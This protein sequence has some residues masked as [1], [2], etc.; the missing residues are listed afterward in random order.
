MLDIFRDI[1]PIVLGGLLN[2]VSAALRNYDSVKLDGL[3]RMADFAKWVVAAE[4]A[5]P[6]PEGAF[7]QAYHINQMTAIETSLE[8]D[9]LGTAV[10]GMMTTYEEWEGSPTELYELLESQVDET[11]RNGKRWPGSPNW[12]SQRLKRSASFLRSVGID[13]QFPEQGA[14]GKNRVFRIRTQNTVDTVDTV[15]DGNIST[16]SEEIPS[17]VNPCPGAA[18]DAIDGIDDKN[19]QLSMYIEDSV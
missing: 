18:I 7:M 5:L 16:L 3:P 17:V 8:S 12:M 9:F 13:I 19:Q 2:A 15:G 11:V 14:K 10:I 1:H 6:W 4:S